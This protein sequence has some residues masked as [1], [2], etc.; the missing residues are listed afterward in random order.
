MVLVLHLADL[1]ITLINDTP[2]VTTGVD[3]MRSVTI[4]FETN[5]PMDSAFCR[6]QPRGARDCKSI[7]EH[8]LCREIMHAGMSA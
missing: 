5:K 1:V 2:V 4:A 3:G 8:Q 6:L 7:S